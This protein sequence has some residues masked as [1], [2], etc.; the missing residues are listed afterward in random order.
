MHVCS[1][2]RGVRVCQS[3]RALVDAEVQVCARAFLKVLVHA[4]A[5]MWGCA[6][7]SPEMHACICR[8]TMADTARHRAYADADNR[9]HVRVCAHACACDHA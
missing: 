4:G 9:M 2:C 8:H 6:G 7:A 1:L 5:D 3:A